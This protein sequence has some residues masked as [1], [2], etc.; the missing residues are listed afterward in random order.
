M[1][2]LIKLIPSSH[3][4]KGRK[5]ADPDDNVSK[6]REG[7]LMKTVVHGRKARLYLQMKQGFRNGPLAAQL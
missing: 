3:Q 4:R 5:H 7:G 2:L 1:I 6:K